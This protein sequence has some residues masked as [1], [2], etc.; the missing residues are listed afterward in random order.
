MDTSTTKKNKILDM[1]YIAMFAGI[2]AVCSWISIPMT[3]P[4]TLQTF[5]VFLA[6]GTLGGRRGSLAVL[7]YILLGA[8]GLPVFAGFSGGIGILLGNTGGYIVGFLFTALFMWG[9]EALLG[10]KTWV[11]A[12]SMVIGL[13][14]CYAIGTVW[15]MEVYARN[16]GEIG[17]STVLGFCVIPFIVP[18]LVKMALALL[19]S[20]RLAKAVRID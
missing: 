2:M 4:F 17:L 9:M 7:V 3:V 12:L 15:F 8:V 20:K 13:L 6:V 18:D 11:L 16:T 19:V 10:K 1:A 5:A 14:I